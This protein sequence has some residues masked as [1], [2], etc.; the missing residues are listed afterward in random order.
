M[1]NIDIK[2]WKI[3]LSFFFLSGVMKPFLA[4][5]AF[6]ASSRRA[7]TSALFRSVSACFLFFSY[8]SSVKNTLNSFASQFFFF[9]SFFFTVRRRTKA[10]STGSLKT[11]IIYFKYFSYR[12]KEIEVNCEHKKKIIYKKKKIV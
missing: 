4:F 3:T 12:W 9:F 6:D 2:Y 5:L 10:N 7:R 8:I 11:T 1:I